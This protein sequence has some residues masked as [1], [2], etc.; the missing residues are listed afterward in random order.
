MLVCT[1]S[2]AV[3]YGVQLWSADQLAVE[4]VAVE[5]SA[6]VERNPAVDCAVKVIGE[7]RRRIRL[8]ASICLFVA[9]ALAFLSDY[10]DGETF[11]P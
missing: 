7:C 4:N 10:G 1:A 3:E 8:L 9:A 2:V 5:R 6:A 11:G